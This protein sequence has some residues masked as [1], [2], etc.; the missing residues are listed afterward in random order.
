MLT[1]LQQPNPAVNGDIEHG[2]AGTEDEEE[3]GS[4]DGSESEDGDPDLDIDAIG[5][6]LGESLW[7]GITQ[8]L[9]DANQTATNPKPEQKLISNIQRILT[10]LSIDSEMETVFKSHALHSGGDATEGKD[11]LS[12]LRSL[13]NTGVVDNDTAS[14]LAHA[15][16]EISYHDIFTTD[17]KE[18][19]GTKRKRDSSDE[20][21]RIKEEE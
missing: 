10:F 5:L 6:E 15:A 14:A 9:A 8:S 4:S 1:S 2:D 13:A 17:D 11:V 16:E 21:F 7:A 19:T 3:V 12:A 20:S 18:P